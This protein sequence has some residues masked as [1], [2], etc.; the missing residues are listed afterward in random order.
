MLTADERPLSYGDLRRF[1]LLV[2]G[3]ILTALVVQAVAPTL[4]LFSVVFL[5]AMV[6]NPLVVWLEK[7][8]IKR[9]LAVAIVV[10]GLLL[11]LGGV[12][13]LVV[14][15]LVEQGQQLVNRAPDLAKGIR[16]QA[17]DLAQSYP[18]LKGLTSQFDVLPKEVAQRAQQVGGS[19]LKYAGGVIG[20]LV[21]GVF[22]G[23]LSVL[24]LVFTLSNPQPLVAGFLRAVPPRHR[25]ASRRALA[26]MLQQMTAWGKA[27]LINGLLTGVSTGVLMH[28]IGVQ[29]ALVFGILAFFGE[30]VPNIGPV[31]TSAPALFVALSYGPTT[32]AYALAA[33]LFVQQVESN[34]LVPFV[35]GKQ[36][37]LHPVSIVFS[38]LVMGSLFGITGAIIA[39]PA[40]VLVKILFEEFYA[41]PHE[42]QNTQLEA[43]A[44]A[45]VK[46]HALDGNE[47]TSVKTA[48]RV[49]VVESESVEPRGS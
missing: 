46:G 49:A 25:E 43:Q 30:F 18:Q 31:V 44:E 42:N 7:R 14:P 21:G 16:K 37:E 19:A 36:L 39:V 29:P 10:L 15:P 22:L 27:T 23:L 35:M 34:V 8:K 2:A 45:I 9:G 1:L 32:A 48:P 40:A 11:I 26:R 38:A 41:R 5:L 12:V 47:A 20:G 3:L 6:L 13:A 4:L 33:I 28:F 17:D 24:L